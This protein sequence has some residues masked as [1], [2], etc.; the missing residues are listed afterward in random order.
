MDYRSC[1]H[2]ETLR[3]YYTSYI[4]VNWE[5]AKSSAFYGEDS[6]AEDQPRIHTLFATAKE[7]NVR[8]V[9]M[10]LRLDDLRR[11]LI[12]ERF[13]IILL[14]NLPDLKCLDC[15]KRTFSFGRSK[16]GTALWQNIGKF[17]RWTSS[18]DNATIT[19][20]TTEAVSR[21]RRLSL[22]SNQKNYGSSAG[23]E[24]PLQFSPPKMIEKVTKGE[25][26]IRDFI[27]QIQPPDSDSPLTFDTNSTPQQPENLMTGERKR[28]KSLREFIFQIQPEDGDTDVNDVPN[29]A[30]PDKLYPNHNPPSPSKLEKDAAPGGRQRNRS[31]R[32]YIFPQSVE[33]SHSENPPSNS[34]SS[35]IELPFKSSTYLNVSTITPPLSPLTSIIGKNDTYS[36][37]F[38]NPLS[39]TA[40]YSML[41]ETISDKIANSLSYCGS[42]FVDAVSFCFEES[43]GCL[44][45]GGSCD[46]CTEGFSI[47][48]NGLTGAWEYI[49]SNGYE[50]VGTEDLERHRSVNN[51]YS[52]YD[53]HMSREKEL[54]RSHSNHRYL[55]GF[56][57]TSSTR[58]QQGENPRSG[59]WKK[60][61]AFGSTDGSDSS[62]NNTCSYCL[63]FPLPPGA[64]VKHPHEIE[65]KINYS[66]THE[67]NLMSTSPLQKTINNNPPP[68]ENPLQA[69]SNTSA[70][71]STSQHNGLQAYMVQNYPLKVEN[72]T[73]QLS[74]MPSFQPN[75]SEALQ[76]LPSLEM[77]TR[78]Q[79]SVQTP[80]TSDSNS[81]PT[82]GTHSNRVTAASGQTVQTQNVTRSNSNCIP[83]SQP[84]NVRTTF[85]NTSYSTGASNYVGHYIVIVGYD[86]EEDRFLYRD[87]GA[88]SELCVIKASDLEKARCAS[89]TDHDCIVVKVR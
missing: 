3:T 10:I 55:S 12:S 61:G 86:A 82:T 85:R 8:V 9:Q 36:N 87:P 47:A 13:A 79:P 71:V 78:Q 35:L 77:T 37:D 26:S 4:G 53:A 70:K 56:N 59:F 65:T 60:F 7:A 66:S 54:V 38:D 83:P 49:S 33:H 39:K 11:F 6:I 29:V 21:T 81:I 80:V 19:N 17:V 31:V 18:S 1:L 34:E 42:V 76:P 45:C 23:L 88:D 41:T 48:I 89:G 74:G 51:E 73:N 46:T 15:K 40:Q 25:F 68:L 24:A 75:C 2:T 30:S 28:N 84:P 32:D 67:N 43:I 69:T 72:I 27:F 57:F 64:S 52:N 63:G 44:T 50:P 58:S 14:V 22:G 62:A 5:S 16:S 20:E